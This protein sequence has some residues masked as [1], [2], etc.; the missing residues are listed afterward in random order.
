LNPNIGASKKIAIMSLVFLASFA[1][2]MVGLSQAQQVQNVKEFNLVMNN[3]GYN[4]TQG[5][6]DLVVNQG[7]TVR[8]ILSSVVSINHDFTLDSNSP[9][10]YNAKSNRIITP[11]TTTVEFVANSAGTFKYY[12]SVPG[13]RGRGLEGSL[14]V[15]VVA[16]QPVPV[17]PQPAPAPAPAPAVP[18]P[19]PVQPQPAPVPAPQQPANP[20]PVENVA[21]QSSLGF[22]TTLVTGIIAVLVVG[23]LAVALMKKRKS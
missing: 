7:D 15:N 6:P 17:Q 19:A 11:A 14:I 20:Q 10:P 21:P 9:S 8:I 23:G 16:A 12:C 18:A 22:D 3:F 4:S 5:G 13:H 1:G 2:S